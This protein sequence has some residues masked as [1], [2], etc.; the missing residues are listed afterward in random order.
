MEHLT[1][2][3]LGREGTKKKFLFFF[4]GFCSFFL[5]PAELAGFILFLCLF[6][7]FVL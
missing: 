5:V 4:C 1:D 2:H 7:G 6:S 3:L